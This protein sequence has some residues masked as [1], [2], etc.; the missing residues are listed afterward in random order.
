MSDNKTDTHIIN[1]I[2]NKLYSEP[3]TCVGVRIRFGQ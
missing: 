2:D 3:I 1:E